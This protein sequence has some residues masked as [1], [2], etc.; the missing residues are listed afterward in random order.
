MKRVGRRDGESWKE[1]WRNQLH[2]EC[3]ATCIRDLASLM[4][5]III[6]LCEACVRILDVANLFI[7]VLKMLFNTDS[8]SVHLAASLLCLVNFF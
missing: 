7:S 8:H 2:L 1:R 3:L 5:L 6:I 4:M